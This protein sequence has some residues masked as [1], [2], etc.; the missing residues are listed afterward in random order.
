MEAMFLIALVAMPW[1]VY[2][3]LNKTLPSPLNDTNSE[4][5]K[6]W[7]GAMPL[8]VTIFTIVWLILLLGFI[9]NVFGANL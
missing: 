9:A 4:A 2:R 7:D 3:A 6:A 8:V 1:L 5:G